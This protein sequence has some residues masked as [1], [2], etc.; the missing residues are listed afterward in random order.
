MKKVYKKPELK[1]V[2]LKR[3]AGL[4]DSSSPIIGEMGYDNSLVKE[5]PPKA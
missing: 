1:T 2:E 5:I 4:L 3:R